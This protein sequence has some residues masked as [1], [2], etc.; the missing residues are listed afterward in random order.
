[1][2]LTQ[3]EFTKL[4]LRLSMYNVNIYLIDILKHT[5]VPE[6]HS[7]Y[8]YWSVTAFYYLD[9]GKLSSMWNLTLFGEMRFNGAEI[10]EKF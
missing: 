7:F 1:M 9:L 10:C 8:L 5:K 6:V 4:R 3:R 2:K